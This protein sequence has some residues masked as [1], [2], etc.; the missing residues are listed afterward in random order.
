MKEETNF[1]SGKGF[2]QKVSQFE[3]ISQ[4]KRYHK[5]MSRPVSK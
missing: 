5:T 3:A 4:K 2:S 1:E